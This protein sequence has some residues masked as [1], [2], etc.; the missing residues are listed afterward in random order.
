MSAA[1][2]SIDDNAVNVDIVDTPE[3]LSAIHRAGCAAVIWWRQPLNSF[4]GWIDQLDPENLPRARMIVLEAAVR[5]AVLQSCEM[6]GTPDCRERTLLVDDIAALAKCFAAITA[7]PC[8]RLRLDVIHTNACRKFHI[9]AVTSRLI[10]T[11][12]GAGTEYGLSNDGADPRRIST[13]PTGS[14]MILRGTRWPDAPRADLVHRSPQ[15]EGTGKTRL[16][17]VLD[18]VADTALEADRFVH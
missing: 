16:V 17:L 12:R 5:D 4:Q 7:S 15:I 13:A 2:P 18:P 10:C 14:P 8:L 3:D 1:C 6:A 11:Y 9:D